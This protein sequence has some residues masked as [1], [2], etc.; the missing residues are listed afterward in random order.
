MFAPPPVVP[1]YLIP[2][3]LSTLCCCLPF[4]I[5]AVVFA[6]QVNAKLAVGDVPG[7]MASSRRARMWCWVAFASGAVL[8][9]AYAVFMFVNAAAMK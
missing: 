3:I 7:A 9:F 5:V 4:G 2:S 8:A 6:A 1:N